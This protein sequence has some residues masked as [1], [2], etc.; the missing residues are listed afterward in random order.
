MQYNAL[1]S[2]TKP[3][4][5]ETFCSPPSIEIIMAPYYVSKYVSKYVSSE[6]NNSIH[7]HKHAIKAE[8]D[9]RS[10]RRNN[11]VYKSL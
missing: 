7:P 6:T 5:I 11:S 2:S 1:A 9:N 10:K 4:I 8:D 3:I